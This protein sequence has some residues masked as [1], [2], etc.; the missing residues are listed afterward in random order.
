MGIISRNR[1]VLKDGTIWGEVASI[2][3]KALEAKL[4]N[5]VHDID[6]QQVMARLES[7][8]HLEKYSEE[9]KG[10]NHARARTTKQI[11]PKFRKT[12][13]ASRRK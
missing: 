11:K 5:E 1:R 2:A 7:V 10:I 13:K 4:E 12:K 8:R 6:I 3:L 9:N